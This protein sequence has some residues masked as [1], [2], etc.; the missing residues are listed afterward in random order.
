MPGPLNPEGLPVVLVLQGGGAL[1]AYQ[2]GVYQAMHEHGLTPDWVVGTS[3]GAINAGLI[4]GNPPGRR[5]ERL[6]AFWDAVSHADGIDMEAV[7]DAQRRVQI[8]MNTADIML[9][10]TPGFF[11]PRVFSPFPLGVAVDPEQASF[12]DT[13]GLDATLRALVDFDYLNSGDAIRLT[14]NAVKVTSGALAHFDSKQLRLTPDHIRA[15]CSLPPGFPA[16]RVDGELY[17]DGGLYSNTPLESVLR[18]STGGDTLCFMVDLWSAEGAEPTTLDEV[19][20]RQKDV[21]YASR[22][23]RHIA[24]YVATQ[25]LTRKLQELRNRLPPALRTAEDDAEL[26][27]LGC[28]A[29]LHI[30]N[31]RYAGH[32]WHMAAKDVNFTRG[33]IEWRWDQGYADAGCALRLAAWLRHPD[34]GAPV[35]MHVLPSHDAT[36]RQ[37]D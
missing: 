30:V 32:D 2:A 37:A 7:S 28:E 27:D 4:A 17:W 13:T 21:T 3:I 20:T 24:D 6:K 9:R 22:S 23:E 14:V 34:E 16:V 11:A 18:G 8:R 29:T 25:K 36:P 33:S 1:G 31:L 12:Y 26:K 19:Y 35:V 10:G 15:S 5:L